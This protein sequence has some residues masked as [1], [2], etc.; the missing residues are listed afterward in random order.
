MTMPPATMAVVRKLTQKAIVAFISRSKNVK[1][2]R[3]F[4]SVAFFLLIVC[5]GIYPSSARPFKQEV[6]GV[7]R[8]RHLHTHRSDLGTR[9]KTWPQ[10]AGAYGG[11]EWENTIEYAVQLGRAMLF[12][13]RRLRCASEVVRMGRLWARVRRLVVPANCG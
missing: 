12:V 5:P 10:H 11:H 4:V 13:L 1:A 9:R 3:T 6:V 8:L 7:P 2:F